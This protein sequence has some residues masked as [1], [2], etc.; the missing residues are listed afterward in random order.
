MKFLST[1]LLVGFL[2]H[3]S[4]AQNQLVI[5]HQAVGDEIDLEEKNN[6]PFLY[7]RLYASFS[8]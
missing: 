7:I 6:R 2:S 8:V 4:V 1:V 5:L 3:F